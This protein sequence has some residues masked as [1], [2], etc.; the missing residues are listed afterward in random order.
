MVNSVATRSIVSF[1][2][3]TSS[4]KVATQA[5][6]IATGDREYTS[7]IGRGNGFT[8]V[9]PSEANVNI[10]PVTSTG[11]VSRAN[12]PGVRPL[13]PVETE[14]SQLVSPTD[15]L[16]FSAEAREVL[17]TDGVENV[18]TS[19]RA[20]RIAQIKADIEAGTYDTD[21]K[22]DAAVERMLDKLV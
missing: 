7:H 2:S 12:A 22:F 1:H 20:E 18:E 19:L 5:A 14:K 16:A 21:E 9:T 4:T 17:A 8:V 6:L 15:E 3:N 13:A 11:G 10:D